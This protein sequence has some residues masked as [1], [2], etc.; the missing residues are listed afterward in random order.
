MTDPITPSDA[1]QLLMAGGALIDPKSIGRP[2]DA[3]ACTP[4]VVVPTGY[5]VKSLASLFPT[6]AR[7]KGK[8]FL[9][10]AP[11]F[12]RFV[13]EEQLS[14]AASTRVFGTKSPP[15]FTAVFNDVGRGDHVAMYSCPLS[16]EWGV[17]T[18]KNKMSMGQ[19]AF[20][21][22]IED[23][24]LDIIDPSTADML[25]VAQNI[26][27]TTAGKFSSKINRVNGGVEFGFSEDTQATVGEGRLKVPEL[28]KIAIPVLDGG[29]K[30]ELTARLRYRIKDGNL[31]LYYDLDSL[32]RTFELAIEGVW[33]SIE[34]GTKQ[35]IFHGTATADR[36]D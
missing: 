35:T 27:A 15:Q 9:S 29:E 7:R 23:N 11:S 28:F 26:S 25:E 10:D 13:N 17:W 1:E 8:T 24:R 32:Q 4:F 6:P 14:E 30:W 2:P 3:E 22:F 21:E 18:G 34:V 31:A 20:A 12:I 19:T 5:N 16:R 33:Q 36:G